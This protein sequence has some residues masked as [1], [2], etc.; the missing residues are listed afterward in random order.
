MA[1]L[2]DYLERE[3]YKAHDQAE[4]HGSGQRPPGK[5]RP[6][7]ATKPQN[8]SEAPSRKMMAWIEVPQRDPGRGQDD[9]ERKGRS[10]QEKETRLGPDD[11]HLLT[12]AGT[13]VQLAL[14]ARNAEKTCEMNMASTGPRITPQRPRTSSSSS[15]RRR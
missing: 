3:D 13:L 10:G 8:P 4:N 12:V 5:P 6:A 1:G 14:P 2:E 7:A 15:R 11:F 9:Q